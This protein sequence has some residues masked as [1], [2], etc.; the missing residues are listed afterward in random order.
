LRVSLPDLPEGDAMARWLWLP[1]VREAHAPGTIWRQVRCRHCETEYVFQFRA[2]GHGEAEAPYGLG[3]AA[4]KQE[5]QQRAE[6]HFRQLITAMVHPV[7]CP[8]CGMFQ[9]DMCRVLADN[10]YGWM[11]LVVGVLIAFASMAGIAAIHAV[12]IPREAIFGGHPVAII[13]IAVVAVLT[14]IGGVALLRARRRL[15]REY[16]PNTAIPLEERLKVADENRAMLLSE[17]QTRYPEATA[18][19]FRTS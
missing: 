7:P 6:Y 5:A 9:P 3:G 11:N 13:V 19:P 12:C 2:V 1:N 17:F 14:G 8:K 15:G 10:K 18:T 4:A 16:D